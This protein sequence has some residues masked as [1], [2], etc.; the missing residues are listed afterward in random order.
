LK[1][2]KVLIERLLPHY[3]QLEAGQGVKQIQQL[4]RYMHLQQILT[5]L[6][7]SDLRRIQET[8]G[9]AR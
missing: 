7:G 2:G 5:L 6:G 8:V 1:G 4:R 3:V 9:R